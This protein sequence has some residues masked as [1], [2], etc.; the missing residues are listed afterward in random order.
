MYVIIGEVNSFLISL[1][2]QTSTPF[3]ELCIVII[4][5]LVMFIYH[6]ST[7]SFVF[8]F[9]VFCLI[10]DHAPSPPPRY[11]L[12]TTF[13]QSLCFSH[14]ARAL[15]TRFPTSIFPWIPSSAY[16]SFDTFFVLQILAY[17]TIHSI[18]LVFPHPSW[19][20]V[21]SGVKVI[22]ILQEPNFMPILGVLVKIT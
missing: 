5:R 13:S 14:D 8:C 1:H 15:P 18:P 17:I 4:R 16:P 19:C 12:C 20:V 21:C 11:P 6:S 9:V 2:W 22:H 7:F 10:I 3:Y